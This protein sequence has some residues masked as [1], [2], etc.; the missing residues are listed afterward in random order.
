MKILRNVLLLALI[1][2]LSFIALDILISNVFP[3]IFWLL[4]VVVSLVLLIAIGVAVVY[5]YRKLRA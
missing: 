4:K 1:L 5:L 2:V 3:F